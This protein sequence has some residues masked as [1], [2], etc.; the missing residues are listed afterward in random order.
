MLP[1]QFHS[2]WFTIFETFIW[3]DVFP[4]PHSRTNPSPLLWWQLQ[5]QFLHFLEELIHGISAPQPD[6]LCVPHASEQD[7]SGVCPTITK[8]IKGGSVL[9]LEEEDDLF[10]VCC[11]SSWWTPCL[12]L[13]LGL[14]SAALALSTITQS[15]VWSTTTTSRHLCSWRLYVRH[16]NN[17]NNSKQV[18]KIT[19]LYISP[20]GVSPSSG[21]TAHTTVRLAN[22]SQQL[23]EVRGQCLVWPTSPQLLGLPH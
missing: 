5:P 22:G 4:F 16:T 10:N 9:P 15:C 14:F 23:R 19:S 8:G 11:S 7:A 2:F 3:T 20:A 12:H 18:N 17:T 1:K 6:H 21:P 13:I